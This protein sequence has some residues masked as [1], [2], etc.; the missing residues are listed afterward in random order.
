MQRPAAKP[1][2]VNAGPMHPMLGSKTDKSAIPTPT[3][4]V[5]FPTTRARSTY[6]A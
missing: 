3:E 6:E 2:K 1:K 5:A 4:M